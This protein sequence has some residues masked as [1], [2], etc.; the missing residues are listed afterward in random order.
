MN[1]AKGTDSFTA[2][3]QCIGWST[4]RVHLQANPCPPT[5]RGTPKPR[6][7]SDTVWWW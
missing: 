1:A 4:V 6:H 7:G 2:V 3:G 5:Q